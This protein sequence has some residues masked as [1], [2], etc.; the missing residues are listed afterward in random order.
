MAQKHGEAGKG[1]SGRGD[2]KRAEGKKGVTQETVGSGKTSDPNNFA[3]DRSRAAA[4][5]RKGG[6][7]SHKND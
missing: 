6:H 2:D 4:A 1:K 5:G 7:N 3:N